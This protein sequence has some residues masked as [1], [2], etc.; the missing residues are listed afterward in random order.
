MLGVKITVDHLVM[1]GYEHMLR[2]YQ[3]V[4]LILF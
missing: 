3:Q 4:E 2:K 1:K